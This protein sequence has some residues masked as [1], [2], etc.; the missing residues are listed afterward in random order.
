MIRHMVFF[1][2]KPEIEKSDRD[3]LFAQIQGLSK[4]TGAKRMAIS[5]LLEPR[6]EWYKDR[7]SKDYGWALTMEFDDEDGLYAYQQHPEHVKV[8]QEIRNRVSGF[9]VVD[10]VSVA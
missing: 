8:A 2:L 9:K 5:R 1:N 4:I 6:E 7:V 10:V 3:W